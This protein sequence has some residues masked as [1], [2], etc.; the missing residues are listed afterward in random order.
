[1][2][3]EVF[4]S[5]SAEMHSANQPLATTPS[6]SEKE[7]SRA[8]PRLSFRFM[9]GIVT[10]GAGIAFAAR[11]AFDG[12]VFATAV[13]YS[14]ATVA[15]SFGLFAALFLIA[16]IPA[17][18]GR[19]SLEDLNLGNPFSIDQLPPQVLPPRDPGT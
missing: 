16:W 12:S 18:L 15:I 19:D 8:L 7:I 1:M 2:P 5:D 11:N 6:I 9:L 10:I 14:I 13:I 4:H 3:N 17:I